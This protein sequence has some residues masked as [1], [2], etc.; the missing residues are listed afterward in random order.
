MGSDGP[1]AATS[2][3]V[4]DPVPE[5]ILTLPPLDE[6]TPAI[7]ISGS[8]G[9]PRRGKVMVVGM[10]FLYAAAMSAAASLALAWWDT[11]H[12]ATWPHAI[13]LFALAD[14]R[15]G[16]WQSVL[17]VVAMGLIGAAMVTVPAIAGFNAWNGYRWSRIAGIVAVV[18]SGL[19]W[20]LNPIAWIGLPLSL[21][22]AAILWTRPVTR[23]YGHWEQFRGGEPRRPV[24]HTHVV[25]GPLPR[26][27]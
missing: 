22:G 9:Q 27:H 12:V 17:L 19:A 10:A 1:Q 24:E 13:R 7:P 26:F 8:T 5:E 11:I 18:V 6:F 15:A 20:F 14:V 4:S 23:Y 21:V 25:Y 3:P 2:A 16:S